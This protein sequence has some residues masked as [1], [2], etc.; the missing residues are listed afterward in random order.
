MVQGIIPTPLPDA[1]TGA[2]AD[3]RNGYEVTLEGTSAYLPFEY[4]GTDV[5]FINE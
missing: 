1:G 5:P 2:S 3:D 4:T